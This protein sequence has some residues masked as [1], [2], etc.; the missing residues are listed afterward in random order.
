MFGKIKYINR[1]KKYGYIEPKERQ[2]GNSKDIIFS[3]DPQDG[4]KVGMTVDFDL[5]QS[6]RGKSLC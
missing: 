2:S 4:L 5:K 6:K 3:P 1:D